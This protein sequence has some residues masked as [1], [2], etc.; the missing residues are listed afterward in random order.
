MKNCKTICRYFIFFNLRL[1]LL[2]IIIQLPMACSKNWLDAKTNSNLTVPTSLTD[3]QALLDGDDNNMNV[4][5][6]GLGEVGSDDH[7]ISNTNNLL[8]IAGE[9]N[10]YI[11][12][13]SLPNI[14]I[15]DWVNPYQRVF[16][17]NVVL[18][19][20]KN[21]IPSTISDQQNL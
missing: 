11:W 20:L 4:Y 14:N 17:C 18:D 3:F 13:D 5:G 16:Y 15:S 2:V 19:G 8:H 9:F 7:Y 21:I 1:L 6:V 10:A 12:K